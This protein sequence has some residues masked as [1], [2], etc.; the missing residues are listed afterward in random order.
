MNEKSLEDRNNHLHKLLDGYRQENKYLKSS[1]NSYKQ[2]FADELIKV[3]KLKDENK[4][5]KDR[6]KHLE[7]FVEKARG[8]F[9]IWYH[10]HHGGGID[11][12]GEYT[13]SI[14]DRYVVAQNIENIDVANKMLEMFESDNN[15]SHVSYVITS[16]AEGNDELPF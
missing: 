1:N 2:A 12:N 11:S 16:P 3:Y 7:T 9:K 10:Y 4:Y 6:M 13:E 5:L 14:T 8:G 15:D